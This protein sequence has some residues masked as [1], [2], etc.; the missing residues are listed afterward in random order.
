VLQGSRNFLSP[1]GLHANEF[2]LL[3]VTGCVP[4]MFLALRADGGKRLFFTFAFLYALAG[5][6]L[7]FSRGAWLAFGAAVLVLLLHYR[8]PLHFLLV[9]GI[10]AVVVA[11]APEAVYDRLTT[12]LEEAATA[13]GGPAAGEDDKLTA[14]RLGAW[15]MLAPEVMRS[16]LIG[17]GIGSTA[18]SAPVRDG[19]YPAQHPH[20]LFLEVMLDVGLFGFLALAWLFLKYWRGFRAL[21]RDEGLSPSLRAYFG[22]AAAALVGL[23]VMGISNGHYMPAPEQTFFWFS[24]G[25]L[26][27]H[28]Q[29]LPHAR[30]KA[31]VHEGGA[32]RQRRFSYLRY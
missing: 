31:Q 23:V 17:R 10:I 24:L 19:R 11:A 5:L 6:L 2:G 29:R 3:L 8:R 32:L 28:W 12:G 16:P 22:G 15:K 18:W 14:G 9:G 13:R 21:S 4:L 1:F 25:M 20:N 30:K 7:T 26:F 27:G